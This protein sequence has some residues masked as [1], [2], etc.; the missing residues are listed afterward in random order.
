M[1]IQESVKRRPTRYGA[2]LGIL[3]LVPWAIVAEYLGSTVSQSRLFGWGEFS[4]FFKAELMSVPVLSLVF[5]AVLGALTVIVR[6]AWLRND[7]RRL[8]FNA[9]VAGI[10]L[11]LC[12]VILHAKSGGSRFGLHVPLD[13]P[14]FHF[15]TYQVQE[16]TVLIFQDAAFQWSVALTL[17]SAVAAMRLARDIKRGL[18]SPFP[19]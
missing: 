15:V 16:V 1:T 13:G 4:A 12:S 3:V 17:I 14:F 9:L 19:S 5:G 8:R 7:V 6:V 11:L 10:C 18:K 2:T